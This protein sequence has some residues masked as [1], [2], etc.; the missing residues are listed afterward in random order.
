[1]STSVNQ[2][3]PQ[4]LPQEEL[5]NLYDTV[6][7]GF[8]EVQEAEGPEATSPYSDVHDPAGHFST[9]TTSRWSN[10]PATPSSVNTSE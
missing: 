5:D 4:Q 3:I 6:L 2:P 1:M 9:I 10:Q 8:S 7:Q